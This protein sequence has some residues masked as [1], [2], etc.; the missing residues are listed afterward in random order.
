[1]PK[2]T[3]STNED[4][5]LEKK[6]DSTSPPIQTNPEDLEYVYEIRKCAEWIKSNDFRKVCL[7]FPDHLLPDSSEV[8]FRLQNALNQTVYILGDTAYESCCIDYIAAAHI[9][10][11]AIIHYGPVCFSKTS[12]NIPFFYIFEKGNLD[13][14]ELKNNFHNEFENISGHDFVILVD[15]PYLHRL[16][17]INIAFKEYDD[18]HIKRIDE[19][20]ILL[21]GKTVIFLGKNETKLINIQFN[22]NPKVLYYYDGYL[23]V[24]DARSRILKKRNFL[25][26]KIKDSQTIG[27]VI[28]TLGVKNYLRVIERVKKLI[29]LRG[30]KYYLISVGKPTVAKLANFP[31]LDIYVVI[32]CSMSEIYENRD[33]YKPIATPFDIEVALNAD[34]DKPLEFSYDFNHFLHDKFETQ[35]FENS[36]EVVG[37]VSLLSNK[38][39]INSNETTL[40]KS[41]AGS[42][43][44]LKSDGTLSLSTSYGAGYLADRSWKG[45]EQNL[46]QTEPELAQEGRSGIAQKYKNEL[47]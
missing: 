2:L 45:L 47:I 13:V 12:A 18:V 37:D 34:E 25:I 4:V 36:K 15:T 20:D 43:V 42:Q 10:A 31:E 27:I 35:N 24:Y 21:E 17:D 26:E 28:G 30:K 14:G 16:D 8:V 46:G 41:D 32:T 5:S 40:L 23:K 3:F 39:R 38:I 29:S 11:D 1:M 22:F 7:Q 9:S 33:F 6:I 19:H 44:A